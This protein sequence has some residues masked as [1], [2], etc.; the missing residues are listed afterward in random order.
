MNVNLLDC[1][2]M[3]TDFTARQQQKIKQEQ[4]Q[5]T[6]MLDTLSDSLQHSKKM[7]AKI[8]KNLN[9]R[10]IKSEQ[11]LALS[12]NN[13][14]QPKTTK[15]KKLHK[16]NHICPICNRSLSQINALKEHMKRMHGNERKGKKYRS[17]KRFVCYLCKYEFSRKGAI[18]SHMKSFHL[19]K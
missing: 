2:T 13:S 9:T 19:P 15:K 8:M 16:R 10:L 17:D 6:Q 18:F 4:Q 1:P 12:L 14:L 7:F 11:Q 5:I 3:L